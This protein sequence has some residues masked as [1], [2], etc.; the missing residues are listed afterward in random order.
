MSYIHC[1]PMHNGYGQYARD[2]TTHADQTLLWQFFRS[3]FFSLELL[4]LVVN[5][6]IFRRAPKP[7]PLKRKSLFCCSIQAHERIYCRTMCGK[8]YFY[9]S[10]MLC[11]AQHGLYTSHL[12]LKPMVKACLPY[13]V[14]NILASFS[15]VLKYSIYEMVLTSSLFTSH[16]MMCIIPRASHHHCDSV[17]M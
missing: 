9:F 10:I 8:S 11:A 6:D 7:L 5:I 1:M 13:L 12:L 16:L 17:C 14:Y 2:L 15:D 4:L 3:E